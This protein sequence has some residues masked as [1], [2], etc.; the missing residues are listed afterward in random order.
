YLVVASVVLLWSGILGPPASILGGRQLRLCSWTAS[1]HKHPLRFSARS[2]YGGLGPVPIRR[3]LP[4]RL[5]WRRQ[6]RRRI[7]RPKPGKFWAFSQSGQAER[8][9]CQLQPQCV[10]KTNSTEPDAAERRSVLAGPSGLINRE[11]AAAAVG[12]RRSTATDRR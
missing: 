8:G 2:G 7:A 11:G 4:H 1:E 9:N 10:Q 12:S 6:Y 3:N 5:H